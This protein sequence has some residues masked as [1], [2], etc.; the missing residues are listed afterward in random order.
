MMTI[1]LGRNQM[2]TSGKNFA[3]RW[4]ADKGDSDGGVCYSGGMKLMKIII[5]FG[6]LNRE[7]FSGR[8]GCRMM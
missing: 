5:I 6:V 1:D 2:A 7:R 4:P 3:G 8:R